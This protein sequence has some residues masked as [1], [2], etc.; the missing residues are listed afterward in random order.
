MFSQD[1]VNV[2]TMLACGGSYIAVCTAAAAPAA[3]QQLA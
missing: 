1:A 2:D 3:V